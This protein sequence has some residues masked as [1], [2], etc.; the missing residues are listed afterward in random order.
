MKQLALLQYVHKLI[1]K[2]ATVS[3]VG[4]CKFGAVALLRQLDAWE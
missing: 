3:S 4:D 1:P 2:G